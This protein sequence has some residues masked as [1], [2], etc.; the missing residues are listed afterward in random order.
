M[1][2][3]EEV[4]RSR[5]VVADCHRTCTLPSDDG[6]F[7]TMQSAGLRKLAEKASSRLSVQLTQVQLARPV[8]FH[9]ECEA[10]GP[11]DGA[12]LQQLGMDVVQELSPL[13]AEVVCDCRS[14]LRV[15]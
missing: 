7:V 3:S 2:Q 6:S 1:K 11:I 10:L 4:F 14:D 15:C 13:R 9:V 5:S 8:D 12:A